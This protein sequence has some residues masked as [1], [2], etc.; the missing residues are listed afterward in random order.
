[1]RRRAESARAL[2]GPARPQVDELGQEDPPGEA[3]TGPTRESGA[4]LHR[5]HVR[6]STLLVLGRGV[7]LVLALLTQVVIVRELSKA[8]F[9]AF[10]FALVLAAGMRILLSLGLGRSLSRFMAMYE[11]EG[12]YPRMFGAMFLSILTVLATSAVFILLL[13][14]FSDLLVGSAVDEGAI[15]LV[16]ILAFLAPLEAL[17]QVFLSL[18]AVFSKPRAIFVRKHLMAPGLRLVVVL[19]LAVS[20]AG[21]TFLA[22]GYLLAGVLGILLYLGLLV[23]VLREK[24]LLAHL[25][26]G[27]VQMPFRAVFGFSVPLLTTELTLLSMTA[28]SVIVLAAY[29]STVEVAEY[30]AVFSAARL[31]TAVSTTF[32]TLFLP[33]LTRL[34]ARGDVRGMRDSYWHTATLVAVATFPVFA[35]TG[36]FARTT[37]VTLFEERYA[38]SATVMWILALG[39]Y[40][41]VSLGFNAYA[42][43]VCGRIRYLVGVNVAVAVGNI[44]LCLAVAEEYGAPGVAAANTVALISQNV[45]N[46]WA[47]RGS[48]HTGFIR[49]AFVVPY[50]AIVLGAALLWATEE[51]LA[52]GLGASLVLAATVSVLVL[53]VSRR[54]LRV[55]ETFPELTR[56]PLLRKVVG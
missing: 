7:A 31:N 53:F 8:D 48:I 49:R 56:V 30:R 25:R 51:V 5:N 13:F 19:V 54:T 45:L 10:A 47:L 14:G 3:R 20:G 40:V 44:A 36:P 37:T 18:F 26:P 39:Y 23:R 12:D 9:G 16:L 34:H 6:G 27:R 33:V 42:L 28:G 2:V 50:L 11:E 55:S 22:V 4:D 15:S 24:G 41:N 35:L 52:P 43:Q 38:A 46:Q 29:Q 32:V 17:D 21:V 1:M